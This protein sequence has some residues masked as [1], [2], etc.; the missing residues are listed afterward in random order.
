MLSSVLIPIVE[1]CCQGSDIKI[2][3]T[4]SIVKSIN[5]FNLS[6]PIQ[7]NQLIKVQVRPNLI[8]SQN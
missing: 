6:T 5:H 4:W 2:S 8:H 7:N 3:K 1:N